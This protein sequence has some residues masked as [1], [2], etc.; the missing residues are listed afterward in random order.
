MGGEW[1]ASRLDWPAPW[2]ECPQYTLNRRLGGPL[3]RSGHFGEDIYI[4]IYI[5]PQLGNEP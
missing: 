2:K 4:Y 5:L 1:L 3:R